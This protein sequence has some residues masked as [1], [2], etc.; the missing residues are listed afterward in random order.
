MKSSKLLSRV[1]LNFQDP[2]EE[3]EYRQVKIPIVQE[4][5]IVISILL[6]HIF[7]SIPSFNANVVLVLV[8]MHGLILYT[9]YHKI[10]QQTSKPIL[11]HH[12][13]TRLYSYS[14]FL[15]EI[16]TKSNIG[17]Y[18]SWISLNTDDT[19]PVEHSPSDT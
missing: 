10:L 11:L 6:C 14:A 8:L 4:F 15:F 18:R 12:C 2:L 9:S 7:F 1:N 17:I 19:F 16:K 13:S 3:K 5:S